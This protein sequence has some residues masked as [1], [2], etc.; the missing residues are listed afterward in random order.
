MIDQ[1]MPAYVAGWE[2]LWWVAL[3]LGFSLELLTNGSRQKNMKRRTATFL[4]SEISFGDA[5]DGA[6]REGPNYVVHTYTV[7]RPNR[8][9]YSG[10]VIHKPSTDIH[11]GRPFWI[12]F[13]KILLI[14]LNALRSVPNKAHFSQV[15]CMPKPMS[16]MCP[17]WSRMCGGEL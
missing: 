17:A 4:V 15:L 10:G 11:I 6:R 9:E 16:G 14:V 8:S 3:R 12:F 2:E 13:R 7:R 1:K 5:G